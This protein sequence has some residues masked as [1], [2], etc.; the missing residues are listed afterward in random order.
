MVSTTSGSNLSR[1]KLRRFHAEGAA[2]IQ[3]RNSAI[4]GQRKDIKANAVFLFW[5]HVTP[6]F[7]YPSLGLI[8]FALPPGRQ[9]K[10]KA[11]KQNTIAQAMVF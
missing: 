3:Q 8:V 5:F 4:Q 2:F 1:L 7:E 9:F 10:Y 6:L 11:D